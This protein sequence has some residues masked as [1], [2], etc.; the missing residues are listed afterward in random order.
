MFQKNNYLITYPVNARP[1]NGARNLW[2]MSGSGTLN[3]YLSMLHLTHTN[4]CMVET[5]FTG[6]LPGTILAIFHTKF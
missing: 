3:L 4:S 6:Y 1:R 2:Q 5:L